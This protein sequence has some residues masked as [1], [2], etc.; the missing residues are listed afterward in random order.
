MRILK[1]LLQWAW[2]AAFITGTA[3]AL[4]FAALLAVVTLP[5][6][7]LYDWLKERYEEES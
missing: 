7:A 1:S 3:L 5:L 2:I 4:A 6:L